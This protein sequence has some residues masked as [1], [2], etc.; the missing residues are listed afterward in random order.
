[1][2]LQVVEEKGKPVIEVEYLGETKRFRPEEI[3]AMVLGKMKET[4]EEFLG[5]RVT[6]SKTGK[7]C[8][9]SSGVSHVSPPLMLPLTLSHRFLVVPPR[10][11]LLISLPSSFVVAPC[12]L[13]ALLH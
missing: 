11:Q 13:A 5:E 6:V 4:A 9:F 12:L 10:S 7:S 3:S 1:M 8:L 2:G